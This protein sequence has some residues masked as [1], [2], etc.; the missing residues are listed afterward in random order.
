M[1]RNLRRKERHR[2]GDVMS[3]S[4][5]DEARRERERSEERLRDAQVTVL[6]PLAELR[7]ENHIEGLI[8]QAF[9]RRPKEER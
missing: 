2:D 8:Q 6:I 5:L 3:T 1:W 4:G 9:Q 7:A